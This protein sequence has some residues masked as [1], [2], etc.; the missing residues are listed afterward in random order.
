MENQNERMI[1]ILTSL[2]NNINHIERDYDFFTDYREGK[3]SFDEVIEKID[4][5]VEK[6][7]IFTLNQPSITVSRE[8]DNASA[9]GN[10]C[11]IVKKINILAGKNMQN[12]VFMYSLTKD[13]IPNPFNNIE[14]AID[15]KFPLLKALWIPVQMITDYSMS[16]LLATVGLINGVGG[17]AVI[18]LPWNSEN[19]QKLEKL[20][21]LNTKKIVKK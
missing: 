10:S 16:D 14:A 13:D 9:D 1:I 3:I 12:R 20:R 18:T 7:L 2:K 6:Y 19:E 11:D 8:F 17:S 15:N 5:D 21:E 4:K